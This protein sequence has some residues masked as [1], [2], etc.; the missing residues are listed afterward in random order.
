MPGAEDLQISRTSIGEGLLCYVAS[1]GIHTGFIESQTSGVLMPTGAFSLTTILCSVLQDYDRQLCYQR[2][3]WGFI[4]FEL[5]WSGL[6][7]ISY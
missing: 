2:E 5:H 1:P 4:A 3:S 7:A 6:R